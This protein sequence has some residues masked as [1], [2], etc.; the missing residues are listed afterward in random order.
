MDVVGWFIAI[1]NDLRGK[2]I[3]A[4]PVD[5]DHLVEQ[6][7]LHAAA[8]SGHQK[9]FGYSG[10]LVLYPKN[11]QWRRSAGDTCDEGIWLIGLVRFPD[12]IQKIR[13]SFTST[14]FNPLSRFFFGR[15]RKSFFGRCPDNRCDAHKG[16]RLLLPPN[17]PLRRCSQIPLPPLIPGEIRPAP[18]LVTIPP[19]LHD[20]ILIRHLLRPLRHLQRRT[21][22]GQH[23]HPVG[24]PVPLPIMGMPMQHQI[25]PIPEHLFEVLEIPQI[26]IIRHRPP[27]EVMMHRRHPEPARL[28]MLCQPLGEPA[29]LRLS[30]RAVVVLV[31]VTLRHGGI[32]S[33][34]HQFKIGYLE[35]GPGLIGSELDA[36]MILVKLLEKRRVPLPLGPEWLTRLLLIRRALREV[37]LASLPIDIVIPRHH[38]HPIPG[39][40]QRLHQSHHE[41]LHLLELRAHPPLAEIAGENQGIGFELVIPLQPPEIVDQ[42]AEQGIDG[43]VVG[44]GLAV[45]SVV[46]PE[47]G[48][49]EVEQGD[50]LHN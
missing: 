19:Y 48:I 34:H 35:Q 7:V 31:P 12:L 44:K 41:G 28:L 17:M 11:I 29:K 4:I 33:R 37:P 42:S 21:A 22:G 25:Y 43:F 16:N 3:T 45:E 20:L 49:G 15:I 8:S 36:G 46:T 32:Q 23:R 2:E 39:Q 27:P 38:R 40:S 30:H 6:R 9:Y 50:G 13:L 24:K 1:E 26:L 10:V 5:L 47:L 14:K 18:P